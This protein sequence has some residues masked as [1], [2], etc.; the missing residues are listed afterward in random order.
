MTLCIILICVPIIGT[1]LRNQCIN[2]NTKY[3]EVC[4][5]LQLASYSRRDDDIYLGLLI[6]FQVIFMIN[7]LL[8]NEKYLYYRVNVSY[9]HDN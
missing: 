1:P 8:N 9:I 5:F 2:E 3:R 7:A 4:F 6:L